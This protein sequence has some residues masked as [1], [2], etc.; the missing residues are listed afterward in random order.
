MYTYI[1][2]EV[3]MKEHLELKTLLPVVLDVEHRLQPIL[4]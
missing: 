1:Y 2:L 4:T 3:R